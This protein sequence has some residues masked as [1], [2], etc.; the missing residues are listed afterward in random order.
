MHSWDFNFCPT[1]ETCADVRSL[2]RPLRVYLVGCT[3]LTIL[4]SR[5]ARCQ[6]ATP[7]ENDLAAQASAARMQNDVPRAIELYSRAV[8]QDPKWTDGWWFLGSLQYGA[9]AYGP[10]R[11]ALSRYI[12]MTPNAGPA[13][14]LRGLCE[15]EI[16]DYR[17]S[18]IDIEH[19]ISLGAANQPRNEQI[20][21]YHQAMLLTRLGN[22]EG[23]LK[24]YAFFAKN[25][26]TNPELLVGIGL[27]GL[28]IPLLPRELASNQQELASATGDAA[29]RFLAGDENSAS[30]AFQALFQRFPNAT[31]TH[32]FYGY[33]L[34]AT[35]PEA[36]LPEF[37]Q[38]LKT[39]PSNSDANVMAAWALL[40]RNAPADA[41]PYAENA[42][43]GDPALSSAQ[44]VL[45]RS[46]L[47]TGDLK[48]GMEH[49]EKALQ[50][51]PD[52]IE[53]HLA[54]AK[55][56]SKSGRKEDA[57]RERVLCLQLSSGNDAT[58]ERP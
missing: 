16:G 44:L 47:E 22:Y 20:L 53:T 19:G 55:A 21:R 6:T 51:E 31:N 7:P 4:F 54:L 2:Y 17:H 43:A 35:D 50:L 58:V 25:G 26:I 1:G 42:V 29:F 49:L 9:A 34:F 57:R 52:N 30:Q 11:D 24:A 36:A 5:S 15:F 56:Y 14:A 3:I 40:M 39:S 8:E 45:G 18:L 33:L 12:E 28:R 41:L 32:F 23:A 46:L 10:A 37:Q 13:F 48:G 27:A 38:E